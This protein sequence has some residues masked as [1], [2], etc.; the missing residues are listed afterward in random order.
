MK[1]QTP[2]SLSSLIAT[3]LTALCLLLILILC[4]SHGMTATSILAF[5]GILLL[6]W[7]GYPKA[8]EIV[9]HYKLTHL[10]NN[11]GPQLASFNEGSSFHLNG[12]QFIINKIY[13]K[14]E[15]DEFP[16]KLEVRPAMNPDQ[17]V[18]LS[19][20]TLLP[21]GGEEFEQNLITLRNIYSSYAQ[22]KTTQQSA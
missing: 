1:N 11:K 19:Y 3:N 15:D 22:S 21:H 20:P 10:V 4:W 13:F 17:K 5:L 9:I 8:K 16:Y 18:T 14:L 7:G 6:L 2:T 12:V